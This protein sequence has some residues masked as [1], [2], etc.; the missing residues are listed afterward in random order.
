MASHRE[1]HRMRG[2]IRNGQSG[3]TVIGFLIL[4][5]LVGVVGLAGIRLTPM[6]IKN[7]ALSR[8]L[9]DL[10][11]QLRG[12]SV[13]PVSIR[14]AIDKRLNIETMDL[15]KDSIKITPSRNGYSVHITYENRAPYAGGIYLLLEFDKQVEIVK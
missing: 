14:T 13:S 1:R 6:Y 5:V 2:S 10:P 11:N 8:L 15:P 3:I 9:E 12:D 7:M 4:A